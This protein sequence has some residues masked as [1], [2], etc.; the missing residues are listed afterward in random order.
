M[1]RAVVL[2]SRDNL[3][4]SHTYGNRD[5]CRNEL[6]DMQQVSKAIMNPTRGEQQRHP[7]PV[8]IAAVLVVHTCNA[9]VLVVHTCNAHFALTIRLWTRCFARR[10]ANPF[11]NADEHCL[12]RVH[13]W[14][15]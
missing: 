10:D 3:S 6:F 11:A 9:H 5:T 1:I 8:S 15:L 4:T 12:V 14:Y 7:R 13:V 2:E